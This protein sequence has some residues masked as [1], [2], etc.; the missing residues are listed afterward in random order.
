MRKNISVKEL[1][2]KIS[3]RRK[4]EFKAVGEKAEHDWHMILSVFTLLVV[5][6]LAVNLYIFVKVH[7]GKIFTRDI[8]SESAPSLIDKLSLENEI[9]HFEERKARFEALRANPPAFP[10]PSL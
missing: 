2:A 6:S 3:I 8:E 10:D 4:T 7:E 9:E 1:W 5:V